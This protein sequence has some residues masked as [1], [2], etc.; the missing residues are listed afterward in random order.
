MPSCSHT[1][2]AVVGGAGRCVGT[3]PAYPQ[4]QQQTSATRDLGV[5]MSR[6][7]L[8]TGIQQGGMHAVGALLRAERA[9][10]PDIGQH[11]AD[12]LVRAVHC[13]ESGESRTILQTVLVEL[14]PH[15]GP[16]QP[17]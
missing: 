5:G 2:I 6:Y 12:R 8:E 9:R 16:I 17:A 4:R 3:D 1:R 13:G 7:G 11:C 14:L 15:L 10:K